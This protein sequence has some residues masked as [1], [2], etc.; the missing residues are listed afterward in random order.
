MSNRRSLVQRWMSP[1]GEQAAQRVLTYLAR[2]DK[3]KGLGFGEYEG[4]VDLRGLP[5]PRPTR[6][7][8]LVPGWS[9]SKLDGIITLR[10]TTLVSVD[11]SD[12]FLPSFSLFNCRLADCRFD[13]ANC[14][15]WRFWAVDVTDCSFGAA[16]LGKAVLGPWY[17]GHGCRYSRTDFSAADLRGIVCPTA[18]FVDCLF[19]EA[20]LVNIDFQS[21]SFV[22]CRFSGVLREVMFYSHGFRTGK[23]DPNPMEDVDFSH[24][25]LRWVDFR[26]LNLDR[27]VFPMDE[28]HVVTDK[29]PCVLRRALEEVEDNQQ[30]EARRARAMLESR[31]KWVGPSQDM[32]VF[33]VL[34]MVESGGEE[35]RAFVTGLLERARE[36]C[37]GG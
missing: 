12:A 4:R 37:S 20:K 35:Y 10:G 33:S 32:G 34:D 27:V 8:L 22:R 18:T 1:E 30:L 26:G 5:G 31:L 23:D 15:D 6:T 14:S 21:T 7:R 19:D 2:G 13:R 17:Q 36:W 3:L 29:Y 28:N 11:L 24:A 16:D 9:V 25:V